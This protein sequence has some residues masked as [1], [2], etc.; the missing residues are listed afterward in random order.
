[1]VLLRCSGMTGRTSVG[2]LQILFLKYKNSRIKKGKQ[3]TVCFAEC[4]SLCMLFSTPSQMFSQSVLINWKE[5]E[6][7]YN[8]TCLRP[9]NMTM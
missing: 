9:A 4:D 6:M 5:M 8:P 3:S 1:M 2:L 7:I